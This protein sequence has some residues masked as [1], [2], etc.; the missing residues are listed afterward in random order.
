M[1]TDELLLS[2]LKK[3][4]N[5]CYRNDLPLIERSMEQASVARI[6]YYMQNAINLENKFS[7]LKQYN[8]DCEYNKNGQHIK[9]TP[10]CPKGTRP[11][12]I[13]HK[14]S[15]ND[16]NLIVIEFKP[17]NAK[18]RKKDGQY[19]DIIKLEDFT[20]DV[21]YNYQIGVLVKLYKKEPKYEIYKQGQKINI[22]LT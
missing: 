14:R 22:N 9:T 4:V 10:R 2:L 21:I 6:Y 1:P 11:D 7:E 19:I 12:I 15:S 5:E 3:A 18:Y 17:R 8:L 13:L 16:T 20:S